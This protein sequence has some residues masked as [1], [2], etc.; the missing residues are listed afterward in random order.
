MF[1]IR[2]HGGRFGGGGGSVI[3]SV[4]RG[5]TTTAAAG[6]K[7]TITINPVDVSKSIILM[8]I[9][10]DN[11]WP[12]ILEVLAKIESST[13]I[14]FEHTYRDS[15]AVSISWEVVEFTKLKSLQ[16]GDVAQVS[17]PDVNVTIN[18]VNL[19]KTIAFVTSKN[20]DTNNSS[21]RTRVRAS[22]TNSTTLNI[23]TRNTN[24]QTFHYQVV[25]FE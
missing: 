21:L 25:E 11:V 24:T 2:D 7:Q 12:Q 4:Q 1:D 8:T 15:N 10:S 5:L 23:F 6:T 3:K 13:T 22:L 20:A 14:S 18:A 9:Q 16:K 17:F 19:N